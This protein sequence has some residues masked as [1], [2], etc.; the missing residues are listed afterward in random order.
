MVVGQTAAKAT[1]LTALKVLREGKEEDLVERIA[2]KDKK[3]DMKVK[4]ISKAEFLG[5]IMW[6]RKALSTRARSWLKMIPTEI[7][8]RSPWA[9]SSKKAVKNWVKENVGI[10]GEDAILWGKWE[11]E[12]LECERLEEGTCP[13]PY[14]TEKR[15]KRRGEPKRK[16]RRMNNGEEEKKEDAK[17]GKVEQNE[18]PKMNTGVEEN[19]DR[20]NHQGE[21]NEKKL[22]RKEMKRIKEARREQWRLKKAKRTKNKKSRE[23]KKKNKRG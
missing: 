19:I 3:G 2:K 10:K 7:L 1:I 21:P 17:E 23:R 6:M 16:K 18:T 15:M 5:M 8:E 4:N 14:W 9:D 12:D 13:R 11:E 22:T 20:T